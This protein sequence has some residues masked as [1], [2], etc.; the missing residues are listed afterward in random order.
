MPSF[1]QHFRFNHIPRHSLSVRMRS[2]FTLMEM[3]VSVS[4]LVVIILS[5]G[6]I[7]QSAGRTIG[8]SQASMDM[9]SNVRAVQQQLESDLAVS[10]Q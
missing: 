3:V 1:S 5:V 8:I 4:I 10:P 7:F 9:L 2:A 6:A